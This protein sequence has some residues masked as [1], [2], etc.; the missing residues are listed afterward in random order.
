MS[1]SFDTAILYDIE[2]LIQGRESNERVVREISLKDIYDRITAAS[3]KKRIAVQRAYANWSNPVLGMMRH[4]INELGIEP[5]QVFGFAFDSRKNAADIQ[6]VIDAID[7]AYIRP[8]IENYIIVSG[9]GGFAAL[10]NKLHQIGRTVIGCGYASSSSRVF[11]AVCDNFIILPDPVLPVTVPLL[12]VRPSIGWS[13]SGRMIAAPRGAPAPSGDAGE[14]AVGAGSASGD[15]IEVP[16]R[17]AVP[18]ASAAADDTSL[19]QR[20]AEV[21]SGIERSETG[22]VDIHTA[23]MQLPVV[24]KMIVEAIPGF[25]PQLLGYSK[26]IEFLRAVCAGRDVGVASQAV[27]ELPVLILRRLAQERGWVIHADVERRGAHSDASYRAAL[28]AGGFS[29]VGGDVIRSVAGWLAG[30]PAEQRNASSDGHDAAVRALG[31]QHDPGQIRQVLELIA[32]ATEGQPGIVQASS[33]EGLA[34]AVARYAARIMRQRKAPFDRSILEQVIGLP[35][36]DDGADE[37]GEAAGR[38]AGEAAVRPAAGDESPGDVLVQIRD[39]VGTTIALAESIVAGRKV[40]PAAGSWIDAGLR[41]QR[42][43]RETWRAVEG[44]YRGLWSALDL[45]TQI[46]G[47]WQSVRSHGDML[48]RLWGSPLDTWRKRGLMLV[49]ETQSAVRAI[50]A[51]VSSYADADQ[52]DV[53]LWLRAFAAREKIFIARHMKL[54]DIADPRLWATRLRTLDEQRE[55]FI[56]ARERAG[57]Q[58][59]A[60]QALLDALAQAPDALTMPDEVADALRVLAEHGVERGSAAFR[61]IIGPY[62]E[63][64]ARWSDAGSRE[65]LPEHGGDSTAAG[66][67]PAWF[68]ALAQRADARAALAAARAEGSSA[69]E[70]ADLA[71]GW[72]AAGG[73]PALWTTVAGWFTAFARALTGLVAVEQAA[74]R[75]IERDAGERQRRETLAAWRVA[76]LQGLYAVEHGLAVALAAAAVPEDAD[77]AALRAWLATAAPGEPV[78]D[79]EVTAWHVA[80]AACDARLALLHDADRPEMAGDDAAVRYAAPSAVSEQDPPAVDDVREPA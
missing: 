33:A 53:F 66:A 46:E 25:K 11:R 57:R 43:G 26:F 47:E 78:T 56:A 77:Q 9:D 18:A 75:A 41:D 38:S 64:I 42:N 45:M 80:L 52:R 70:D 12:P 79:Y 54:E 7:L 20:A 40:D 1:Q 71:G 63:R 21:I 27:G 3:G 5:I 39:R 68:A 49:A 74:A 19:F 24:Q 4:S 76:M 69:P 61:G 72:P 37:A 14:P 2:N 8:S 65:V 13:E 10:A 55:L 73:D 67:A 50:V 35:V 17:P 31:A 62:R 16:A 34:G 29:I 44:C 15:A 59:V 23:G 30:Q 51:T 58:R 36:P 32:R 6:L 48:S 28:Q 60:A 22:S